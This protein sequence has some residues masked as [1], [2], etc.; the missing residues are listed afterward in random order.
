M[1]ETWLTERLAARPPR[2]MDQEQ[3]IE[4]FLD[5][6][7]GAWLRPAPLGPFDDAEIVEMLANDEVHWA[8]HGFGPWV[9]ADRDGGSIVGRGGLQWTRI[10]GERVVELPWTVR[11]GLWGLGL[12]TEAAAAAIEWAGTLGLNEVVALIL[13][14]NSS[15]RRV[16][17]KVGLEPE[18]ETLH[19][20]LLHLVYR[21]Q[22]VNG[23]SR[24]T[25]ARSR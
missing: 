6:A 9:L 3:Y 12:G 19:A 15:S 7:V 16:A 25:P 4:L 24:Q 20:G 18:G 8:E 14:T 13:P 11:S 5:P 2:P 17:E 1:G 10:D 21:A 22:T 23:R